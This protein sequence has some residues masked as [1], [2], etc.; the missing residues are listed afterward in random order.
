MPSATAPSLLER[1]EA[2]TWSADVFT[3]SP[4][5]TQTIYVDPADWPGVI[6]AAGS[7]DLDIERVTGV[8]PEMAGGAKDLGSLMGK[9]MPLFKGRA[10]G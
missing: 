1:D 10:D 6:R 2:K 5:Q 9:V 7:L 4:S 3:G 8:R